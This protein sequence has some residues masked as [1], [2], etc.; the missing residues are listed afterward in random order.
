M[1]ACCLPTGEC[2]NLDRQQCIDN[3][4]FPYEDNS[5]CDN[6]PLPGTRRVVCGDEA[7]CFDVDRCLDAPRDRCLFDGVGGLDGIPKGR[8]TYCASAFDCMDISDTQPCC[9]DDGSSIILTPGQ[10]VAVGGRVVEFGEPCDPPPDEECRT[11]QPDHG[12]LGTNRW[13]LDICAN[14]AFEPAMRPQAHRPLA[15]EAILSPAGYFDLFT[16]RKARA[17]ASDGRGQGDC[18]HYYTEMTLADD[19]YGQPLMCSNHGVGERM[20]FHPGM[21]MIAADDI[22][23]RKG[24]A[25]F[26]AAYHAPFWTEVMFDS[27][28][29]RCGEPVR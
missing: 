29:I 14:I 10:C 12:I 11:A 1:P 3:F 13:G 26:V 22:L 6:A 8:G 2:T 21:A 4:G 25:L 23:T 24:Y 7:C 15:D 18:R 28:A 16:V 5:S 27:P 17:L 19:G 20:E 9:F